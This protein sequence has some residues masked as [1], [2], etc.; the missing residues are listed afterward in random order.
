MEFLIFPCYKEANDDKNVQIASPQKKQPSKSQVLLGLNSL[1][2]SWL[3]KKIRSQLLK[4][5][6]DVV[7]SCVGVCK[8]YANNLKGKGLHL[9]WLG[10]LLLFH[11]TFFPYLWQNKIWTI[12]YVQDSE[13]CF[14]QNFILWWLKVQSWKLEIK[15]SNTLSQIQND[16]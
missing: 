6:M 13:T 14:L 16:I 11:K 12:F 7:V 4:C 3:D 8:P 1:P 10:Q 9:A 2:L 5:S 15:R